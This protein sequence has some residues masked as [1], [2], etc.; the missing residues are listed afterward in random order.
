MILQPN[1]NPVINKETLD[2]TDEETILHATRYKDEI[3][4]ALLF[5]LT[6]YICCTECQETWPSNYFHTYTFLL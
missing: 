6:Y 1:N 3:N 4:Y 2:E 5:T